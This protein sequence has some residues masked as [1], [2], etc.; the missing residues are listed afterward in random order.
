MY[1][2]RNIDLENLRRG[3]TPL[4]TEKVV[5][6]AFAHSTKIRTGD[7]QLVFNNLA[8]NPLTKL[9]LFLVS[10]RLDISPEAASELETELL[11]LRGITE[12]VLGNDIVTSSFLPRFLYRQAT[13][14]LADYLTSLS[15]SSIQLLATQCR[16]LGKA[17]LKTIHLQQVELFR[18]DYPRITDHARI[19]AALG[20][21]KK[22]STDFCT[23]T[24]ELMCLVNALISNT[25][26]CEETNKVP[27]RTTVCLLNRLNSGLTFWICSKPLIGYLLTKMSMLSRV[28]VDLRFLS[29]DLNDM[30]FLDSRIESE[31]LLKG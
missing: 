15:L 11:K 18:I 31:G 20:K 21:K 6:L 7:P 8:E 16:I 10:R 1:S 13:R 22:F 27:D 19:Y 4:I 26:G 12:L 3:D 9:D 2:V 29:R 14:Q 30:N 17:L 28:T 5:Q 24:K 23:E 25:A